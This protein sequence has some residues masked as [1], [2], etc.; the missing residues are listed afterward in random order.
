[1]NLTY[2]RRFEGCETEFTKQ[3]E[4][5]VCGIDLDGW[6][7]ILEAFE[8]LDEFGWVQ[9]SARRHDLTKFHERRSQVEEFR[10]DPLTEDPL[11]TDRVI[12]V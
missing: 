12:F 7:V 8:F 1:M 11:I 2:A 5:Y 4:W 10:F 6:Y 3:V 9:V